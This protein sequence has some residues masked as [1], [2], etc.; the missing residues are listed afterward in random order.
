MFKEDQAP[1]GVIVKTTEE[2]V[3]WMWRGLVSVS[4]AVEEELQAIHMAMLLAR[5]RNVRELVIE[6]DCKYILD[7]LEPPI[8]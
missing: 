7:N 4:S 6:G 5:F 3:P 8:L 2:I 1:I